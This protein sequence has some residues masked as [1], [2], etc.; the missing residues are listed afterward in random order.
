MRATKWLTETLL[1]QLSVKK[2]KQIESAIAVAT[3][4]DVAASVLEQCASSIE[5][6][7]K[8]WEGY[9]R[10]NELSWGF[11]KIL[12]NHKF[13]EHRRL[14]KALRDS[15]AIVELHDGIPTDEDRAVNAFWSTGGEKLYDFLRQS[16]G[17]FKG[18]A[19]ILRLNFV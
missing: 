12:H 10:L 11:R 1:K 18:A 9:G 17:N 13:L 8:P 5:Q 15:L 3:F 14:L 4:F 16:A 6:G 7:E 2:S 19:D